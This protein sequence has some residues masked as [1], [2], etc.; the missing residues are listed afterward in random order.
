M[1]FVPFW[2]HDRPNKKFPDYLLWARR[3]HLPAS[4][5]FPKKRAQFTICCFP[6][7]SKF[8]SHA[9]KFNCFT[10]TRILEAFDTYQFSGMLGE[11]CPTLVER[12]KWRYAQYKETAERERGKINAQWVCEK[13]FYV[14]GREDMPAVTPQERA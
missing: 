7:P 2:E 3:G 6:C 14:I 4:V 1:T 8:W 11:V 10:T 5:S 13:K 12:L 9:A